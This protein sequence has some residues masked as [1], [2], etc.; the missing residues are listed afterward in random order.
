MTPILTPHEGEFARLFGELAGSKAERALAAARRSGAVVV[1]KGPDTLVAAPDGRLGFAP[2]APAWLASAGTGDVLAGMIAALRARGMAG[3]RSRLRRR[4]AARPRRRDRRAGDD[5]RRS[6]RGH[7]ARARAA[8]MSEADRP[9]RRARGRGHGERAPCRL[10][11][12]R[13]PAARRRHARAGPAATS[14]RHAAISPNA[15]AASCSMSPTRP[16]A[17]ICVDR[18]AGALAQHGLE[19]E[20]R[21]PHLSPPRTRRRAT[22]ARA[23]GRRRASRIGFNAAKSHP[24][25]RHARMP[26]PAARA[27]RLVAPLRGLLATLLRPQAHGRGPADAGRPGRRRRCSRASRPKGW[28]RPRR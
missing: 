28:R 1:Y 18:V 14:S 11:G 24:H 2:P 19:T 27:V 4:L 9:H 17:T 26:Y 21:E 25:R 16:I 22:P 23:Q 5:R 12:S 15:A 6:R 8:A 13:R 10:R 20:I 7:P 3:V